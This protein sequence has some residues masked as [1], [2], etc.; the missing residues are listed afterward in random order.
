VAYVPAVPA[1]KQSALYSAFSQGTKTL[2]PLV[3]RMLCST[4]G[5]ACF[6]F[7]CALLGYVTEA[8]ANAQYAAAQQAQPAMGTPERYGKRKK[9]GAHRAVAAVRRGHTCYAQPRAARGRECAVS[10][11]LQERQTAHAAR[12]P[13]PQ[14]EETDAR[15][16]G[17]EYI[18]HGSTEKIDGIE[19]AE[20]TETGRRSAENT[21]PA[22]RQWQRTP[23]D[24][25]Q[26]EEGE[27]GRSL[28]PPVPL[29]ASS[30]AVGRHRTLPSDIR[31]LSSL[32]EY[33]R[34]TSPYAAPPGGV[35]EPYARR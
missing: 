25:R 16:A 23:G 8:A 29:Q 32:N 9:D 34:I 19:Q 4:A 22:G 1:Y 6:S 10:S 15:H 27:A 2:S 21:P 18:Q 7:A 31:E 24:R 5:N 20:E 30:L 33:I 11:A 28:D 12:L 26:T 14:I 17:K 13:A 3:D 35:V